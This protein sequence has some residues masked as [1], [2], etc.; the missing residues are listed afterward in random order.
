[1]I[2]NIFKRFFYFFKLTIII[3]IHHNFNILSI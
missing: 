3:Y 1:M 2:F